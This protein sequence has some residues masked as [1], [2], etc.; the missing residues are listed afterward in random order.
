[1]D[2]A[3]LGYLSDLHQAKLKRIEDA[4]DAVIAAA[5]TLINGP[6]D[7]WGEPDGIATSVEFPVD[8]V[9]ALGVALEDLKAAREGKP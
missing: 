4:K 2:A 3:V 1:M 6:G 9:S 7:A 8:N 5:D